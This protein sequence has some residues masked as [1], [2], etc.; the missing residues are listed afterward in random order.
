M[1]R[2]IIFTLLVWF[3]FGTIVSA[4][5]ERTYR[6]GFKGALS[7]FLAPLDATNAEDRYL[8]LKILFSEQPRANTA[9]YDSAFYSACRFHQSDLIAS[10]RRTSRDRDWRVKLTFR[11]PISTS[12]GVTVISE[13]HNYMWVSNCRPA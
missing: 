6:P 4:E 12:N 1:F 9:A 13:R 7:Q 5:E 11:W 2:A 10:A 8:T 3:S